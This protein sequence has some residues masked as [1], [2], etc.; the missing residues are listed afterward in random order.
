[1][2]IY[3]SESLQDYLFDDVI[4]GVEHIFSYQHFYGDIVW[5]GQTTRFT[6]LELM[7]EVDDDITPR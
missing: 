2:K 7:A 5:L 4:H 3:W 6:D 1:M